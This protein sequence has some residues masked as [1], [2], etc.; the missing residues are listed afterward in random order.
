MNNRDIIDLK[1]QLYNLRQ[2]WETKGGCS[3]NTFR[4]KRYFQP[5]GGHYDG[6]FG[7]RGV[8]FRE[9]I[10]EWLPLVDGDLPEYHQKYRTGATCPNKIKAIEPLDAEQ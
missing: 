10:H 6:Y 8:F 5:K 9:T 4:N 2:A 1:M 3:W 7:G